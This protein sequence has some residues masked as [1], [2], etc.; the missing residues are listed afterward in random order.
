MLPEDAK[1]WME[2]G[3]ALAI[4]PT[5][6]VKCPICGAADL[7]V[8][9]ITEGAWTERFM[10]CPVCGVWNAILNPV[11]RRGPQNSAGG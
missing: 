8:G 7:V 6:R 4:D 11:A 2:A 10:R 9:D 3:K 5:A 1:R